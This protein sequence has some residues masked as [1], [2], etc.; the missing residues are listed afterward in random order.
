MVPVAESINLV[1]D[2]RKPGYEG[3]VRIDLEVRRPVSSFALHAEEMEIRRL[4]LTGTKGA[5]DV[6]HAAGER[7]RLDITA[8]APLVPG[9]YVLEIDF[10]NE[11]DTH[12]TGLYKVTTGGDD[13]LFTQFEADDARQAFPCWDEPAFK[14]PYQMTVTVPEAHARGLQHAG[15]PP[16]PSRTDSAR[17]SS[18]ARGRCPRTC[19]RWPPARW[20]SSPSPGCPCPGASSP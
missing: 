11:Y 13:Y 20:S 10:A 15:R 6:T 16:T 18:R 9:R 12:A 5:V 1:A 17:S 7:G 14:I 8:A 19:S 2:A 3:S 4:A